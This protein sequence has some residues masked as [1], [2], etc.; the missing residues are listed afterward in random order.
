MTKFQPMPESMIERAV[1]RSEGLC[2]DLKKARQAGDLTRE[3]LGEDVKDKGAVGSEGTKMKLECKVMTADEVNR[4]TVRFTDT[5][6]DG[7]AQLREILDTYGVAIVQDTVNPDELVVFE[8]M[9]KADLMTLAG[10]ASEGRHPMCVKSAYKHLVEQGPTRWPA[11]TPLGTKFANVG[12]LTSG[13]YAWASRMHPNVKQVFQHIHQDDDLV[14]GIDNVFFTPEGKPPLKDNDYWLHADHN[15]TAPHPGGATQCYQG[16]LYTWPS[17]CPTASTTVVCPKSHTD[18]YSTL[19]SDPKYVGKGHF[20]AHL[21]ASS[22]DVKKLMLAMGHSTARRVPVPAGGLLLWDSKLSHQGWAGGR[23]LAM[24]ICWE[25]RMHRPKDA[26]RRKL[27]IAATGVPS[28]HWATLG[29]VHSLAPKNAST[30][31]VP[32]SDS[33]CGSGAVKLP[34]YASIIPYSVRPDKIAEWQQ[35]V[36]Q[37]WTGNAKSSAAAFKKTA[38]VEAVL[39]EEVLKAL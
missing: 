24:P 35:L 16:V 17:T 11:S 15:T 23:R 19:V 39:K 34:L 31:M 28:T 22:P 5:T 33:E 32:G 12:G 6:G 9:W 3:L 38:N 36:P 14:V 29:V 21:T 30:E 20:L 18:A 25:P 26:L 1:V 4:I 2:R 7:G 37:L 10:H 13:T 27:W 8:E